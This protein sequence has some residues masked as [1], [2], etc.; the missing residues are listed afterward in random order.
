MLIKVLLRRENERTPEL[1]AAH[2]SPVFVKPTPAFLEKLGGLLKAQYLKMVIRF[3]RKSHVLLFSQT[4]PASR[5]EMEASEGSVAAHGGGRFK[6][7]GPA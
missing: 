2:Q 3:K 4:R 1:P 6:K 7:Y 5:V